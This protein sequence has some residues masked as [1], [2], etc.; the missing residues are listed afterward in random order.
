MPLFT[1]ANAAANQ[2]ASAQARKANNAVKKRQRPLPQALDLQEALANAAA[3]LSAD[4][5]N[6]TQRE[7]RARVASAIASVAK[8]RRKWMILGG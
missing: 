6:C 7:E 5:P 1:A 3:A 2:L 4:V 8:G